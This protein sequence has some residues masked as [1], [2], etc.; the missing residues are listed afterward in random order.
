MIAQDRGHGGG[1]AAMTTDF[2]PALA[3]GS[4]RTIVGTRGRASGAMSS[5][6]VCQI[7][8][9]VMHTSLCTPW[10]LWTLW[11]VLSA[12]EGDSDAH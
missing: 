7:G 3:T 9:A 12:W 11:V 2:Y 6:A 4:P 8:L 5:R 1:V 10:E